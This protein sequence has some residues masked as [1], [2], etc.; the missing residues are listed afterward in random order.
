MR[1]VTYP[2]AAATVSLTI[3]NDFAF[4]CYVHGMNVGHEYLNKPGLEDLTIKWTRRAWQLHPINQAEPKTVGDCRRFLENSTA[5]LPDEKR[6][7]QNSSKGFAVLARTGAVNLPFTLD[8]QNPLP[9]NIHD[10]RNVDLS[11]PPLG[12]IPAYSTTQHNMPPNAGPV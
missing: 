5:E 2:T 1:T 11:V 7:Q 4:L 3:S 12:H 9:P 8:S 10:R 6:W